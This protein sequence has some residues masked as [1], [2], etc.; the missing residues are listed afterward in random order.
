MKLDKYSIG[1]RKKKLKEVRR[2]LESSQLN[3]VRELLPDSTIKGNMRRVWILFQD[4]VI[5]AT[6]DD[7]SYAG[8]GNK[9]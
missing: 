5:V 8:S 7:I 6:C 3:A 2:R 4:S 1:H 9:P